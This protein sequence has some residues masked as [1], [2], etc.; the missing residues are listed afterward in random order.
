MERSAQPG[1]TVP[2]V[3]RTNANDSGTP[4]DLRLGVP[5]DRLASRDL[6]TFHGIEVAHTRYLPGE[7]E[8]P[9]LRGYTV[10]LSLGGT[11]KV[12]TRFGGRGRGSR[13]RAS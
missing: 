7:M 3:R 12:M 11:G 13:S 10:N 1:E 2:H 8:V 9:P 6:K 4:L 5:D